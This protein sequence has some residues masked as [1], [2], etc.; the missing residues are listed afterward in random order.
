MLLSEAPTAQP[1]TNGPPRAGS[2]NGI[3]PANRV[4]RSASVVKW[5]SIALIVI[6]FFV[7]IRSLPFDQA[8]SRL[9]TIVASLGPWGPVVFGLA[10]VLAALL[11]IPGSA[12]TLTSGVLF[13]PLWGTATVSVSST[14]AAAIAFLI[15]RYLAREKVAEQAR[16]YPKFAAIDEAIGKGGPRI[17]ALLRLSPAVPFS[18]GN[19]LYGLTSIRF[20]PYVL[21]S[22]IFMLPGTF[23]YAYLGH[24][25]QVGLSAAA[26][27]RAQ[28]T[29]GEWA[30][31]VIGLLA[32][33][34]VTIYVTRLARRAI[35]ERT[36]IQDASPSPSTME[37][38]T[39]T[40]DHS[41]R[42][43]LNAT[44][45]AL[46]AVVMVAGASYSSTHR[47]A[48]RGL[49]GPP[50]VLLTEAYARTRDSASFDHGVFDAL[51][52]KHVDS[53]GGV[54]YSALKSDPTKLDDYLRNLERVEFDRLGRDEK[55]ALLI[56]AYNAFTL[57]LIL[58]NYPVDS[59]QDIPQEQRWDAQ[60][61]NVGGNTWS[62]N[63]IEHEQ[64]RPK[65][66]EPRVHFALVC[67]AIGCPILRN[68][69]YQADRIDEQLEDQ[70]R[71]VHTHDRWFQFDA[72]NGVVR[73]TRLYFWYGGDF[74]QVAGSV[75][76]FAAGYSPEL[77]RI[78]DGG[79]KPQ[80]EWLDYDWK[81]NDKTNRHRREP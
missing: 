55:L 47:I 44:L 40:Q 34:A 39:Q 5:I 70:S 13:G 53:D 23:M 17:V 33:I 79:T 8:F 57:R 61:W 48:L 64:I 59:I 16:K 12:L 66:V 74:E 78:I 6:G 45:L 15:A 2:D 73:L 21:A 50:A 62:L 65:F 37:P 19:Y 32:T 75:L 46:C 38:G 42:W 27:A 31:L 25:G 4:R 30:L 10:Y 58:D 14:M 43:P 77:K 26:G 41:A 3:A 69:A 24:A 18:L 56:N 29:P 20:W 9:Q 7:L 11:F 76:N 67:A 68:E 81:L 51:L 28:R 49:F 1:P 22:A 54:D 60:R 71:Y 63:Q 35:R 52:R 72:Q 36:H 80:I